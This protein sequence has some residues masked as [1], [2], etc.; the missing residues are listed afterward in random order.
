MLSPT[1]LVKLFLDRSNAQATRPAVHFRHQGEYK[2]FNWSQLADDVGRTALALKNL[3]VQKGDRVMLISPNRYEW[4]VADMAIL[5]AGA[6][7][8]RCM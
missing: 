1:T 6:L 3:G 2:H 5:A 4:V 8:C 7:M